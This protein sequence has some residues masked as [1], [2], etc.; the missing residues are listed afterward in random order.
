VNRN[1]PKFIFH[2]NS[3]YNVWKTPEESIFGHVD[4]LARDFPI[5]KSS[6][7]EC[8]RAVSPWMGARGRYREYLYARRD[9]FYR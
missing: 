8:Y 9:A 3:N 4:V 1:R 5:D 7:E 6:Y 2:Q